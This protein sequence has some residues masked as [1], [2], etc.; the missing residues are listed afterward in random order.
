MQS[1]ISSSLNDTARIFWI[2][3]WKVEPLSNRLEKG[4]KKIHLEPRLMRLLVCL[5]GNQGRTVTREYLLDTVWDDCV[6][7]LDT[8]NSSVSKLRKSLN[9]T[10]RDSRYI[11][12]I[13]KIGYRLKP[14][15]RYEENYNG[16]QPAEQEPPAK[17]PVRRT[18]ENDFSKAQKKSSNKM[19]ALFAGALLLLAVFS[20]VW[21]QERLFSRP[22]NAENSSERIL[23]VTS[24]PD[25]EVSPAF[26]RG[27]S[28]E[29]IAFSW[30]G[31]NG[32]NWDIYV[33]LPGTDKPLRLT[34]NE[35][36][37]HHPAW[38][39]DNR[40]IAFT[41]TN[42]GK[43]EIWQV[44]ALGGAEK[45]LTDCVNPETFSLSWSFD[46]KW[47]AFPD[48]EA[49]GKPFFIKLFAT[50]TGETKVLTSPPAN[51]TGD[52]YAVFSPVENAL[53][54]LRSP[55]IGVKDAWI[56][57][58]EGGEPPQRVTFDNLE[59][60]G[61]DWTPD[62]KNLVFS[63]NRGGVYS[64]WQISAGG[65]EPQWLG[66]GGGE[67]N[68]PTVSADG[69]KIA[70]EQWQDEANIYRVDLTRAKA[71]A[72]KIIASTRWDWNPTYSPDGSRIAFNSN[73]SGHPEIWTAD[74][75]GGNLTQKTSFKGT[76]LASPNWSP[77]GRQIVFDARV[78]GNT[79]IWL[80]GQD[81]AQ[82]RRLTREASEE[83]APSF[84][85]DGQWIYYGSDKSGEWQIWK[86]SVN[87]GEPVQVTKNGG[88]IGKESA[89]GKYLFLTHH[90]KNGLWRMPKEGGA[91]TL[92]I[93]KI[94]PFDRNYWTVSSRAI[95]FISRP[96]PDSA[97]VKRFDLASQKTEEVKQ[98][99]KLFRLSK[100][101]VSPDEKGLLVTL[102]DRLE[103][104]IM[105]L[106]R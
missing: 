54:V 49:P 42:K 87:G 80:I 104:D 93:E 85:Q 2:D 98:L 7:S 37:D 51:T 59:I 40:F 74:K 15:V 68:A 27:D 20:A 90:K 13:P 97:V 11:E 25:R 46:G 39:P 55:S 62:G 35:A 82:P 48:R 18:A 61:I 77:D 71:S 32:N 24:Y 26:S 10:A 79:D 91:E 41:R 28:D 58:L 88:L 1:D 19:A 69:R 31:E 53:V 16:K 89:D 45:K 29:R 4:E 22:D 14:P 34:D 70:Y 94:N 106:V 95:F 100:L 21:F 12:T 50:E 57:K 65:G 81:Q 99:E 66:T 64:L 38:S 86:I 101:T 33:H 76:L 92:V 56:I 72:E 52:V 102:V 83:V 3:Q 30:K 63:S 23:P 9:D 47:L 43:C 5:A 44:A 36:G 6:V 73:R 84:S 75:D 67:A 78:D 17:E 105:M 60:Q 103:S 96:T 8:L